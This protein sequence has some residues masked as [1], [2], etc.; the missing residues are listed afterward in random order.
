MKTTCLVCYRKWARRL[1]DQQVP[2]PHGRLRRTRFARSLLRQAQSTVW[3]W[4]V[5]RSQRDFRSH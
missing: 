3:R 1:D 5:R 4:Q 2:S